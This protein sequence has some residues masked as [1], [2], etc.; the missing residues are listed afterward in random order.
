MSTKRRKEVLRKD[1]SEQLLR[2]SC[3]F[4]ILMFWFGFG[5]TGIKPRALSMLGKSSVPH[6]CITSPFLKKTL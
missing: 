1:V 5:S 4:N 3:L 6:S 2:R